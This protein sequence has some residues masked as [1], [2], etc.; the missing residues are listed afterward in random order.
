MRNS[1]NC[2]LCSLFLPRGFVIQCAILVIA[3]DD[4][5]ATFLMIDF[6]IYGT[7]KFGNCENVKKCFGLNRIDATLDRALS[8]FGKSQ[9]TIVCIVSFFPVL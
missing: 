7:Q 4:I 9:L 8:K 1:D 6:E 2:I 3:I 5:A